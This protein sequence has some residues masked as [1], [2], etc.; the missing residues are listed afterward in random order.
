MASTP[1][2]LAA[3]ATS[4]VPG[5]VVT[6]T[7]VH[8]GNGDGLFTSAVLETDSGSVIV[9][10]PTSSTAESQ[11]SAEL[12]ALAALS[13]GA[14]ERL[15]FSAPET[16]GLTRARDTRAVVSTFL[17]GVPASFDEI[18]ASPDLLQSVIEVISSIHELPAGLA[19]SGGLPVRDSEECRETAERLVERATDTGLLPAT[20]RARWEEVLEAEYVWSFQPALVHG[21]LAPETFLVEDSTVTGVLAWHELSLG[22]P[23]SDLNW[24]LLSGS[25]LF[26]AALAKY[27]AI[28]GVSGSSELAIR[29]R[30]YHEL[31]VAKWL[32][33]GFEQ[34]DQSII[35]DAVT[36]L[37]RLV[38]RL[39]LIGAPVPTPPVYSEHRAEEILS[40][41]PIIEQAGRS[42]TAEYE[43]LDEDREFFT[44]GDFGNTM[45]HSNVKIAE[46]ENTLLSPPVVSSSDQEQDHNETRDLTE[47]RDLGTSR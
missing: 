1:F 22:D 2:T 32:L 10:V 27:A 39:G 24:F 46:N 4:A 19:R 41:T 14:R 20:V 43:S 15:P 47:T 42:D 29:A 5:L 17:P 28:R 37:D 7:R 8:T 6:G 16:L 13:E 33:H 36:M 38:D 34:H 11:H 18:D 9:R 25:D 44:E 12:L 31:E 40:Q 21:A 26:D 3:L 45:D 30:F 23:A 35:D